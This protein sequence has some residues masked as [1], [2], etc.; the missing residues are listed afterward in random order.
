M[1]RVLRPQGTLAIVDVVAPQDRRQRR[2]LNRLE[3]TREDCYTRI[4]DAR[5]FAK[6]F[7]GLGLRR[8]TPQSHLRPV[9]FRRW[10]AAS[11]LRPGTAAFRRAQRCFY[12]MAGQQR[13]RGQA[14][15]PGARQ[16]YCYIVCQ[17]LLQKAS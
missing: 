14:A 12:K 16:R 3:T 17:F 10:I 4:R 5:E 1:V 11:H 15:S 7:S 8:R 6:I 2:A 9:S 13:A